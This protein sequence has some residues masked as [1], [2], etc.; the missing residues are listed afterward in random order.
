M[1]QIMTYRDIFSKFATDP[2]FNIKNKIDTNVSK[3]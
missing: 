2:N 3:T 1:R